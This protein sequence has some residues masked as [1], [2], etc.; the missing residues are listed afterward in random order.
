[1]NELIQSIFTDFKVDGVGIPVNFMYYNGH[2][3]AYVVYMHIP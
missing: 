2:D 3:N 1:M